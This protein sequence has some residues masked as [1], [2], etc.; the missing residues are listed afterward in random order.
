MRYA[1]FVHVRFAS[2]HGLRAFDG[3][4]PTAHS[5]RRCYQSPF[6][7]G[8]AAFCAIY[9]TVVT[10][11]MSLAAASSGA[12][13][14]KKFRYSLP[15]QVVVNNFEFDNDKKLKCEDIADTSNYDEP[16]VE[17]GENGLDLSSK[18][19]SSSPERPCKR[20]IRS[21][22]PA[23]S[24]AST[25]LA[26]STPLGNGYDLNLSMLF[27]QASQIMKIQTAASKE[28][29]K[30]AILAQS[31]G[32]PPV[33][34][35]TPPAPIPG[36]LAVAASPAA[37]LFKE[38]D[39]SWHRNPAAAIRSG[40]TNK[41]TPVWKYFVY[42]KG[43][44]LSRCIIGDCTY[45]LKGPHTST[46][47]CHLKKHPAEYAEFQKLKL[48]FQ[49]DYTRERNASQLNSSMSRVS[50][51]SSAEN[52]AC[53][54]PISSAQNNMSLNNNNNS[55][56][57]LNNMFNGN[58][59]KFESPPP[60]NTGIFGANGTTPKAKS[61]NKHSSMTDI[62]NLLNARANATASVKESTPPVQQQLPP[63][64]TS[65]QPCMPE[66][67]VT[68]GPSPMLPFP[69]AAFMAAQSNPFL[70]NFLKQ[71]AM[72]NLN[73]N[74]NEASPSPTPIARSH[75]PLVQQSTPHC[76]V[77]K[78][79]R[80][81]DHKQREVEIKLSLAL[82]AA[83]LPCEFIK[84]PF[85]RDFIEAAQPQFV[86]PQDASQIDDLINTQCVATTQTVKAQLAIA[87]KVA[88][89]VDVLN[90]N[91]S[92]LKSVDENTD[93]NDQLQQ[94]TIYICVSAS[95]FS[96]DSQAMEVVLLGVR[97]LGTELE[98][99][100]SVKMTVDQLMAE[101]DLEWDRVSRVVTNGLTDL[102]VS[103]SIFP[104]HLEPYN[105]EL[106]LS[107]I[108]TFDTN[109]AIIEL[110]K[111]FYK[112]VHRFV[113]R[114]QAL[115]QLNKLVG[116][117]V[118]LPIGETFL[119]LAERVLKIKDQ[120]L[121]VCGD[122]PY[123]N[124]VP[125]LNDHEWVQ[126]EN[127]VKLLSLFRV[128]MSVIHDGRYATIDRVVPSLMQLKVSLE[129]DFNAL[130]DLPLRLLD[131]LYMR[132]QYI[133]DGSSPKFDGSFI[134]ATAL[135]PQLMML[136]DD[137][138]MAFAKNTIEKQLSERMRQ[139]DDA[140]N[141][142]TKPMLSGVDA[143]LA[144]V[145]ERKNSNVSSAAVSPP[146]SSASSTTSEVSATPSASTASTLYPDL[147]Q[148][149]NQRRKLF[150]DRQQ[151]GKNVYAEAMVQSYFDDIMN[152]VTA[153]PS[154]PNLASPTNM[155]PLQFWQMHA[156][157]YSQLSDIAT[158][159]LTVPS[160]TVSLERL[161]NTDGKS[162]S[163]PH[164]LELQLLKALNNPTRMERDAIL[165][166]NSAFIPKSH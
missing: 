23:P 124:P 122:Q 97:K 8:T 46:L 106:T 121:T 110:K 107:L 27:Q 143:L 3:S 41:Q 138:Q 45:M 111:V 30:A 71:N 165:R 127:A 61:Q 52:S 145:S 142:R 147:I 5:T 64:P 104:R 63:P 100:E 140:Q 48:K 126:L 39:W 62:L 154:S 12:P 96:S 155:P 102:N 32:P 131:D 158:E 136:L 94:K 120:F 79:W 141:R 78:K 47:A 166:F 81:H 50:Q 150:Q 16:T 119:N 92:L 88:L 82:A 72:N 59:K 76:E 20:E 149:A 44:N 137:A 163:N 51:S 144:A 87:P 91:S 135:N 24:Q 56:S 80:Q 38:D 101:Y 28:E 160:C 151:N 7:R 89:L 69:A 109:H 116:H 132:A 17:N 75:S 53:Q 36:A 34:P 139:N 19:P 73:N 93:D 84:N 133:L 15:T 152:A 70:M 49:Q 164:S 115:S 2:G 83:Q 114:P 103:P 153:S 129:R 54:T 43:E 86:M 58:S 55:L 159:L 37:Q 77:Q 95:Y 1:A 148:A 31:R 99:S 66:I 157:K 29:L 108:N 60:T 42:N 128:H 65:S 117:A 13:E 125:M 6:T 98:M 21:P 118:K 22:S 74:N 146:L 57:A 162:Q 113:E 68:N 67:P 9:E 18:L 85:F 35:P 130:G 156:A 112:M 25:G 33:V 14:A 11:E 10:G 161:F 4:V 40:G 134:T 26:A 105:R 123:E 90:V